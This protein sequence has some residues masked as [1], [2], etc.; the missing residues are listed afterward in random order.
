MAQHIKIHTCESIL[1]KTTVAGKCRLWIGAKTDSGYGLVRHHGKTRRVHRVMY[2]IK[3]GP[4]PPGLDIDHT[5]ET[6]LCVNTRHMDLVTRGENVRRYY[7]RRATCRNGH[8]RLAEN[9]SVRLKERGRTVV[10]CLVCSRAMD[11][12][13]RLRNRAA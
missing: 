7:R 2:E 9:V 4:I 12:R 13:R 8:P 6:K 11:Q 10:A 5:C 3:H 1:A